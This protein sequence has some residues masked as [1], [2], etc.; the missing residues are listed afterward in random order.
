MYNYG[1]EY[2][3]EIWSSAESTPRYMG[4]KN[5][6]LAG[7]KLATEVKCGYPSPKIFCKVYASISSIYI[8]TYTSEMNSLSNF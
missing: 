6:K 4:S 8:E 3:G 5:L 7:I 2:D 1:P